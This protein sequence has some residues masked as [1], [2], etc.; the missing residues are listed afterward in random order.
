M[1]GAYSPDYVNVM[2]SMLKRNLVGVKHRIICIT[3][4]PNGVVDCETAP[5]WSDCHDIPNASGPTRLPSCYRRLR[6]YDRETQ[7][8]LGI[9]DGE[10]IAGIDLDTVVCGGLR[11]VLETEGIF[12]GWKLAAE[13]HPWVYNGSFQMFTAGRELQRIWSDFD[14]IKSPLAAQRA[15][16]KGSDQAWLS[17]NLVGRPGSADVP[18]PEFASY[19]LHVAKMGVFALKCRLVFFHGR[20]KPWSPETRAA[21]PWVARYW[22]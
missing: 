21:S 12:V 5:L 22:R 3:D 6:L 13:F 8:D 15:G 4:D 20:R 17:M 19:P 14:P 16:F 9:S 2:V 11:E 18:Y 7:R 1:Q 10:R